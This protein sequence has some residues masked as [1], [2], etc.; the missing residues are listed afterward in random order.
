VV[1]F[2]FIVFTNAVFFVLLFVLYYVHQRAGPSRSICRGKYE[3][4]NLEPL[5]AIGKDGDIHDL[6]MIEN[7]KNVID[8][9]HRLL[10][11]SEV[12][13]ISSLKVFVNVL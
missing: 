7:Q 10:P 2:I 9:H 12:K 11:Y 4:G 1:F 6:V 3:E 8:V 13:V 5:M